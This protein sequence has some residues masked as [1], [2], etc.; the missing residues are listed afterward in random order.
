MLWTSRAAIAPQRV[1]MQRSGSLL[2]LFNGHS[3]AD[4]TLEH[5]NWIVNTGEEGANVI[6]GTDGEIARFLPAKR[7]EGNRPVFFDFYS[8]EFVVNPHLAK[9]VEVRFGYEAVE[10]RDGPRCFL[11][12]EESGHTLGERTSDAGGVSS[13]ASQGPLSETFVSRHLVRI[14]RQPTGWF[15][16]L[17]GA[18]LVGLPRRQKGEIPEFRF[19][20]EGGTAWFSDVLIEE[21][22]PADEDP[23][24]PLGGG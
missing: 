24:R 18:D 12:L 20:A 19:A 16:T 21:L 3:L 9:A 11:R 6:E 17:D 2:P 23:S 8:L 15:V 1:A 4:W 5:G 14:E 7:G 22:H 13:T 10:S